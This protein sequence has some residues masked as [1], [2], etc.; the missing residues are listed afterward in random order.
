MRTSLIG[1]VRFALGLA[2]LI[3]ATATV[4]AQEQGKHGFLDRVYKDPQGNEHKYVL[5]VPHD[6]KG[7]K[8]FPLILF[9]HGAGET[10]GGKK[11]PVEVGIGPAIKKLGEKEFPFFVLFPQAKA[12][13]QVGGRWRGDGDN[14]KRGLAMMDEIQKNYQ[15]DAKRIYLTGLSMGGMG[16][17]SLAAHYPE[18]WAA[19]VPICGRGDPQ[20]AA[21]FKHIP[22]WCFHGDAD[23]T[24]PVEGSR[25]MI[26]ALKAAG[27]QPKYD[28]Y[29][30]VGHN[31]WDRAYGTKELYTW[32]L[33]QSLK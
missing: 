23:K 31:S 12:G 10:E 24:V 22:C 13:G 30:G 7:D 15:I 21:K 26:A 2:V 33:Q 28:E 1:G 27:G 17:W 8:P 20:T 19:I 32:L 25:Q 5:F 18:K 16:T 11:T 3:A 6:Y 29:P 4:R 9:L 14:A